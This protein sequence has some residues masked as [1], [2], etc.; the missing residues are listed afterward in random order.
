MNK[1]IL[2]S[3]RIS[4][5]EK[6]LNVYGIKIENIQGEAVEHFYRFDN[7]VNLYSAA[8][9]FTSIGIGILY[10]KGLLSLD[11]KVIDYFPEYKDIASEGSE[12]IS[13]KNLL[14]MAQGKKLSTFSHYSAD[15]LE[16]NDWAELFFK[17]P[18]EDIPGTSFFYCGFSPYMCGRI[19]EKLTG[20]NMFG[21]LQKHLFTPLEMGKPAASCIGMRS[22]QWMNAPDGHTICLMDLYMTLE[23]FSKFG[24][25]LLKRGN[26]NG[27]R[28]ISEEYIEKAS[29][30]LMTN[31]KEFS[32]I[33]TEAYNMK[34]YG[35]FFW[36][37]NYKNAYMT[38]GR[39]GQV[40]LILPD[41]NT[42]ITWTA[43]EENADEITKTV[44]DEIVP[45]LQ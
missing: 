19:V 1:R 5:L 3:F 6:K 17:Y 42:V 44:F 22:P 9:S 40:N 28:I 8:K 37:C 36:K 32:S 15:E 31:G 38:Q 13:I 4:V 35:Y 30:D 18:V 7:P 14:Q 25:L 34:G 26:W 45:L 27:K 33:R 21:F 16:N 29:S 20:D 24:L 23:D 39:Y 43:H 2:D 12:K 11:D 41:E 10:D